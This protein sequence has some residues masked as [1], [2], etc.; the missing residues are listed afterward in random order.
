MDHYDFQN[1]NTFD[2]KFLY[3]DTF[4]VNNQTHKG[5]ISNNNNNNLNNKIKD[6][7]YFMLETKVQ[8]KVSTRIPDS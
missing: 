6:P 8:L 1:N 4:W 5:K 3:N 7:F 2:V